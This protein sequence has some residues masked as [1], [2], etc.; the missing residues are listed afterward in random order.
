MNKRPK[1][2][3][4]AMDMLDIYTFDSSTAI[5]AW[6]TVYEYIKQLEDTVQ[7]MRAAKERIIDD[8]K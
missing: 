7:K 3:E 1:E 4:E 8:L 6:N 5:D 2:I